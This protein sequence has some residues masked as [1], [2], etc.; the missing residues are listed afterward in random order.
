MEPG[1]KEEPRVFNLELLAVY[2][3]YLSLVSLKHSA[4]PR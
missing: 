3:A 2:D 1:L 4:V